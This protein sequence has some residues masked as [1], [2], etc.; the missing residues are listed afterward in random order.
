MLLIDTESQRS[1]EDEEIK[2][3]AAIAYPYA[4]C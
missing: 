1:S 4:D 3:K 2:H